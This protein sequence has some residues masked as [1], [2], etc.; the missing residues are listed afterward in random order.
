MKSSNLALRLDGAEF[1]DEAPGAQP[2]DAATRVDTMARRSARFD[3]RAFDERAFDRRS[4]VIGAQGF[5]AFRV[6]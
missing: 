5:R 6:S 3:Y 1:A 4:I 2:G